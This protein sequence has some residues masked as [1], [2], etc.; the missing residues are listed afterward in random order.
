MQS[1]ES[2][3]VTDNGGRVELTKRR[4]RTEREVVLED[5]EEP[6][7]VAGADIGCRVH[8]NPVETSGPRKP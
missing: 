1:E 7:A 5:D 8:E 2:R 6:E 3:R 4:M